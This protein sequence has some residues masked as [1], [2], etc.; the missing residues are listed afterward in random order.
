VLVDSSV[1]VDYFRGKQTPQT[2][3]IH[4]LLGNEPLAIG[5]LILAEVLQGLTVI[6]I[7]SKLSVC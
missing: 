3:R 7:S 2:D 4:I 5:D 1:W 6:V